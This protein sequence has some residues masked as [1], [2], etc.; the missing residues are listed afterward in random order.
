MNTNARIFLDIKSFNE[1]KNVCGTLNG[2]SSES[3]CFVH[4][5][6]LW[7]E[8][9]FSNGAYSTLNYSS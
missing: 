5:V 1:K 4:A 9:Q 8:D 6:F 3:G 2:A 7:S